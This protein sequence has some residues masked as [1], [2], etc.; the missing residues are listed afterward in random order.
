MSLTYL[1]LNL[2]GRVY[3]SPMPFSGL[4]D[5]FH[6]LFDEYGAH[7]I[8]TVVMLASEEESIYHTGR[9]LRQF[10][11]QKGLKVIYLPVEDFSTP[12]ELSLKRAVAAVLEETKAGRNSVIH[13]HY[14]I[15]R[16]GTFGACLARQALRL[17]GTEALDWIRKYIPRAVETPEQE[18]VVRQYGDSTHSTSPPDRFST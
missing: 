9:N 12:D 13:C 4:V 18:D 5:P 15:G 14:G 7:D 1:P 16:T 10:Y 17:D 8:H 11:Q 2:P 3:A 6:T